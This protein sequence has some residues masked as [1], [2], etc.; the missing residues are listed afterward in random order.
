MRWAEDWKVLEQELLKFTAE[1][2]KIIF[3]CIGN[4]MRGDDSVAP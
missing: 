3:L 2:G 4:E 1:A